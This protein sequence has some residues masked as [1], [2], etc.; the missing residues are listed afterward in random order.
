MFFQVVPMGVLT[1]FPY[2]S[3][4]D[5]IIQWKCHTYCVT[6]LCSERAGWQGVLSWGL[7]LWEQSLAGNELILIHRNSEAWSRL[8]QRCWLFRSLWLVGFKDQIQAHSDWFSR[9]QK[10]VADFYP[11]G[12]HAVAN[13]RYID[14]PSVHQDTM[15]H[16]FF[17][18]P[19]LFLCWRRVDADLKTS[20]FGKVLCMALGQTRASG[21]SVSPAHECVFFIQDPQ[22]LAGPDLAFMVQVTSLYTSFLKTLKMLQTLTICT[23]T[24][25]VI[26]PLK[27]TTLS[28]LHCKQKRQSYFQKPRET[29][30]GCEICSFHPVH[31]VMSP[32]VFGLC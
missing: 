17:M 5:P 13:S 4:E 10:Q 18:C 30:M 6:S 12:H 19:S 20:F 28:V 7:F 22:G 23:S 9:R 31:T 15:G 14:H 8:F 3:Q 25:F 11:L 1:C 32:T 2:V 29:T 21:P 27:H 26:Y 16:A 24:V